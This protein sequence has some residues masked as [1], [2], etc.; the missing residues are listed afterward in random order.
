MRS[1]RH[2]LVPRDFSPPSE[3]ALAVALRLAARADATLHL[4]HVDVLSEDPYGSPDDAAGLAARLRER[5]KGIVDHDRGDGT[6]FD[7]GSVRMEHAVFHEVAAGPTI[8]RHAAEIGADLVVMGRHARRGVGRAVLG[9]IAEHLTREAPCPVAT[10]VP[11]RDTA[12]DESRAYDDLPGVVLC[13]VDL[14]DAS[15]AAVDLA[16]GLAEGLDARLD[17][18]HAGSADSDARERVDALA[19]RVADSVEVRSDIRNGSPTE[20][21]AQAIAET[22][23]D[24]VVVGRRAGMARLLGSVSERIVQTAAT[25]IVVALEDRA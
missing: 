1:I 17:L 19:A 2:I 18:L 10:V 4:V 3:A 15:E 21:I 9:S 22:P 24:L 20:A 13:A 8:A 5:L 11:A 14:S 7:P 6:P 25:P 16:A 23:P 12:D